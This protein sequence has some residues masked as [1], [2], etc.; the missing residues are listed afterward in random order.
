MYTDIGENMSHEFREI[1]KKSALPH[2]LTELNAADSVDRG[3]MSHSD[4]VAH[5]MRYGYAAKLV[6]RLKPRRIIDIGCGDLNLAKFLWRN[7]STFA[8]DYVGAD[9][10]ATAKWLEGITWK[11]N[12]DLVRM[13][14]VQ[15]DPALLGTADLVVCFETFEH[16]PRDYQQELMNRLYTWTAAGGRCLFSTP[17]AG[18]ARSTA[19][20]HFGPDGDRERTYEEKLLMAAV[21]GFTVKD[22]F[23]TFAGSTRLPAEFLGTPEMR[24][25][26]SFLLDSFFVCLAAINFPELSNNALF[27][28]VRNP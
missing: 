12:I 20:N 24:K 3:F 13:D 6:E 21:A 18:V 9:L 10:R 4:W 27:D 28:L 23:G 5:V 11:A 2:G 17:N 15:D 19:K 16:V 14:L 25:A 8:G 22:T 7:R 1:T 26:K